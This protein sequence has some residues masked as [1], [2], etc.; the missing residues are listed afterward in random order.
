MRTASA[1]SIKGK[2]KL[3]NRIPKKGSCVRRL[4]DVFQSNKATAITPY[5]IMREFY[6]DDKIGPRLANRWIRSL[7]DLTDYY[8][9]DIRQYGPNKYPKQYWLVGEWFGS[10]YIDY[11]AERREAEE[12]AAKAKGNAMLDFNPIQKPDVTFIIGPGNA[13]VKAALRKETQHHFQENP[14][15]VSLDKCVPGWRIYELILISAELTAPKAIASYRC[16]KGRQSIYM[17]NIYWDRYKVKYPIPHW[18]LTTHGTDLETFITL[19]VSGVPKNLSL[20]I[21]Y[22]ADPKDAQHLNSGNIGVPRT[23]HVIWPKHNEEA[24][25]KQT[26]EAAGVQTQD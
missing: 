20:T 21:S 3:K 19:A 8:G 22:L 5:C 14:Y 7:N 25:V 18:E 1:G 4:Y 15:V 13:I 17:S 16:Y 23:R 12:K 24:D 10:I 6:P 9:L 11:V 2:S 26:G